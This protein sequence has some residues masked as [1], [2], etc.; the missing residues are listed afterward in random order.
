MTI[1]ISNVFVIATFGRIQKLELQHIIMTGL[2]VADIL[3]LIPYGSV[4][5]TLASSQILL[6]DEM[7]KWFGVLGGPVLASSLIATT[8]WIH[9]GLCIEKCTSIVKPIAHR[10]FSHKSHSRCIIACSMA[11]CIFVSFL[12]CFALMIFEVV[13]FEFVPNIPGGGFKIDR[14]VICL[15]AMFIG[16]PLLIQIITHLLIVVRV[17]KMNNRKYTGKVIKAMRTIALTLVLYDQR[18]VLFIGHLIWVLITSKTS[19]PWLQ[20]ISYHYVC[21]GGAMVFFIYFLTIPKFK[22]NFTMILS[23]SARVTTT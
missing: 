1:L 16:L 19:P 12:F 9:C 6:S 20:F 11:V 21:A 13:K 5:V 7:C 8:P 17:F 3:T 4:I 2:A 18:V 22:G 14:G 23:K 10:E 15:A